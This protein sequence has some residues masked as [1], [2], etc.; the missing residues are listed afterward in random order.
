MKKSIKAFGGVLFL[1]FVIT[2]SALPQSIRVM[3]FNIRLDSSGDGVNVWKNRKANLVSMIKFHKADIVGLQEAQK[4]QI[5]FIQK[6]LPGYVWF[7]VG[8]DDGKEQGEFTAIFYRKDRFDTLETS[9]FW[10]SETPEHPGL[11]W[12]AAYQ[13]ITTFGKFRDKQT[14]KTFYF[15]NTHLDN[16]GKIARIESAKLIKQKMETICGNF[17]V[18]F[19]GDFNSNPDSPPYKVIT[20]KPDSNSIIELFDSQFISQTKHH[21]PSGTFTG[22]NFKAKPKEP[23]DFIFVKKGISVLSH[24]TLSDSFDGFLPSDHYPVLAEII[25]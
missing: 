1:L 23:I 13:R 20:A 7:G 3:T 19:T 10:C 14:E 2:S 25:F 16:E 18:I 17:P 6:S 11:G 5:D 8:R 12:D 21:G 24:G 22:F 4:H 9:T 15:F